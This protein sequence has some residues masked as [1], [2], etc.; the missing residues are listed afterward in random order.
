MKRRFTT[1]KLNRDR[2]NH[3]LDHASEKYSTKLI[4][5][6]KIV[7]AILFLYIPLPLFWSLFDQQVNRQA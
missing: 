3:W 1:E 2:V 7:L 4:A 6:I 5:D